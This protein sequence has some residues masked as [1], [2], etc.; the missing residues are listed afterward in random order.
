MPVPQNEEDVDGGKDAGKKKTKK[1]KK[2][3]LDNL[4]RELDMASSLQCAAL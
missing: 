1:E 2:I 3:E 4:K